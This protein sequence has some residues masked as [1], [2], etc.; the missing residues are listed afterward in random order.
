MLL[1]SVPESLHPPSLQWRQFS[2]VLRRY[3]QAMGYEVTYV[4]NFTDVDDKVTGQDRCKPRQTCCISQAPCSNQASR[5]PAQCVMHST[6]VSPLLQI[7]KRAA[8]TGED[9]L[10]LSA[11]FIQ[12]FHSDM[13]VLN[14][15]A[16]THEPKVSDHI[17]DIIDMISSVRHACSRARLAGTGQIAGL[18]V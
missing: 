6:V 17:P 4:R 15:L 2:A 10:H 16:P 18:P 1:S 7:L 9:P 11:R 13:E 14:C 3:F 8:E 12:E 5:V